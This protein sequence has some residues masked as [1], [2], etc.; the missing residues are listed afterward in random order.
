PAMKET[1]RFIESTDPSIPHLAIQLTHMLDSYMIWVGTTTLPEHDVKYAPVQGSLCKDWSCAMP[2]RFAGIPGPATSIYRS[3]ASDHSLSIAQRLAQRFKKQIFLSL[4]L[5]SS[6]MS[7]GQGPQL[8][9][10]A[11]KALLEAL[12]AAEATP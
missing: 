12:K 5:P 6:I 3:S 4:D 8:L 11:E 2:P 9:L 10:R 7:L 1:Y